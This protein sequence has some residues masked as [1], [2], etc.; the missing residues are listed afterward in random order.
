LN[1]LQ[2]RLRQ[3]TLAISALLGASAI[4]LGVAAGAESAWFV[5]GFEAV[6]LVSAVI[7][8]L[9]GRGRFPDAPA[10]T[11]A[12]IAGAVALCTGLGYLSTGAAGYQ[13]GPIPMTLV[14]AGRLAVAGLLALGAAAAALGTSSSAWGRIALG[15]VL[16]LAPT[17]AAAAAFSEPA[18]P[19]VEAIAS[20]NVAAAVGIA[21][22]GFLLWVGLVSAG[23]HMIITSF[24]RALPAPW[25]RADNST[26]AA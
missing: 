5:L 21:G 16:V 11:L 22:V 1:T 6:V 13:L 12:L 7:G 15:A 8:L 26:D 17:A 10:M 25:T 18:E 9:F 19:L 2:T 3:A 24:E 23:G 14:L 20:L 4:G